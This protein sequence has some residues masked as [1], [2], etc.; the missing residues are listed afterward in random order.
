MSNGGMPRTM[1]ERGEGYD[2]LYAGFGWSIPA[3]FN[4][5]VAVADAW[6]AQAPDRIALIDDIGGEAATM[7]YRGLAERSNAL[8][9]AMR[10]LGV[11]RGDR[12]ALLLPQSFET[13]ISHVAI[14]KL[15]AIAVPLAL[16]FGRRG[17]GVPTADGRGVGG[18]DQPCRAWPSWRRCA[19][20]CRRC[21]P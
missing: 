13:A 2:R 14:Y 8:A 18:G 11:S 10:A 7:N 4:I 20:A 15:G 9:N 3:R 6:A 16:L 5:G 19:R 12:V 17:A 21:T 1:L